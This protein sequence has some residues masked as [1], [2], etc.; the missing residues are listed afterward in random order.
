MNE[1]KMLKNAILTLTLLWSSLSVYSQNADT[2]KT[3]ISTENQSHQFEVD[4]MGKKEYYPLD[5]GLDRG[6]FIVTSDGK[7]QMRILGS[8]R[9]LVVNDFVNF[10]IKKTF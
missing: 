8:V 6:L 10:P 3:M 7:M 4:S 5:I 9:F 1:S 2:T